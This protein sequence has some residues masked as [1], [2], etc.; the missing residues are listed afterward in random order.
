MELVLEAKSGGREAFGGLVERYQGRIYAQALG[1]TGDRTE[2]EEIA[3]ETFVRACER[4]GELREPGAFAGWLGSIV[5]RLA[6]DRQRARARAGRPLSEA[7]HH[8]APAGA[9]ALP[10][11]WEALQELSPDYREAFL[12]V[13]LED[14]S[15]REAAEQIGV[16]LSTV[17]GRVYKA[18]QFLREKVRMS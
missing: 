9:P 14:L 16:P 18:K 7:G 6:A 5:T 17:E 12:L 10:E 4:I 3:Q 11:L 13:H 8:A 15:Y 2:A 1:L